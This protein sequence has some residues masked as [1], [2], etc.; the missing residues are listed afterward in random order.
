[1]FLKLGKRPSELSP[2]DIIEDGPDD[3]DGRHDD[4]ENDADLK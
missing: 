1:M 2:L 4:E 3:E